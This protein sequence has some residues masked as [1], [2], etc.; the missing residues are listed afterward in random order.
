MAD[1]SNHTVKRVNIVAQIEIEELFCCPSDVSISCVNHVESAQKGD[2]LLLCAFI[3][4]TFDNL[5]PD[6][7]SGRQT[8]LLAVPVKCRIVAPQNVYNN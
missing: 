6:N 2:G 1:S 8:G 5:H 3:A 4:C 7:A